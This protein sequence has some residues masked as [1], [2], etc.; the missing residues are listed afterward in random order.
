MLNR[1]PAQGTSQA[2]FFDRDGTLI[3]DRGHLRSPEEVVFFPETVPA[4]RK[5]QSRF[6]F[7]IVTN[8]SGVG[9]GEMT[10][11][12]AHRV[13][14]FVVEKLKADG[15]HIE[16]VYCCPHQRSENCACIKPQTHFLELAAREYHLDLTRSFVIGDHPHDV[17]LAR[18]A[19]ATGIYVLTGHGSKH[20]SELSP[21]E[22]VTSHIGEAA[23]WI[24]RKGT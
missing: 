16:A 3:E 14:A 21:G 18:N 24:L 23:N 22:I 1:S 15:I 6:R 5:L 19:G 13:N 2:I 4:L 9:K 17:E 8:Q 12:E 7:F 20:R 10:L 11:D